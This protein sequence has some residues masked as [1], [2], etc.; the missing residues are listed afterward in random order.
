LTCCFRSGTNARLLARVGNLAICVCWRFPCCAQALAMQREALTTAAVKR[1]PL[2][3][4]VAL[5]RLLTP[6][7]LPAV[8]KDDIHVSTHLYND[9]GEEPEV[10]AGSQNSRAGG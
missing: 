9:G 4:V 8:G 3:V 2:T 1:S 10:T 7:A 6:D 5:P